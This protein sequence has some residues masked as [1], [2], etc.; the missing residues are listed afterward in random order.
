MAF[1]ILCLCPVFATQAGDTDVTLVSGTSTI[2]SP[3]KDKFRSF[4][5]PSIEG[6]LRMGNL[7]DNVSS[8]LES[9][10]D[11][12][13]HAQL[14]KQGYSLYISLLTLGQNQNILTKENMLP[15]Y[16]SVKGAPRV[17]AF[18]SGWDELLLGTS[19]MVLSDTAAKEVFCVKEKPC[20][21]DL[22]HGQAIANRNVRRHPIWGDNYNEFRFRA[23]YEKF[24]N[25][26]A[27]GLVAWGASL[28]RE[29]F[30]AGKVRLPDYDFDKNVYVMRVKFG[31]RAKTPESH[32]LVYEGDA[33]TLT[34]S[35][36]GNTREV[37]SIVVEWKLPRSEAEILRKRLQKQQS[38]ML[39]FRT[40]GT[41][42]FDTVDRVAMQNPFMLE[43]QSYFEYSGDGI[44]LYTDYDMTDKVVTFDTSKV[45]N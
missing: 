2:P 35:T 32:P 44:T 45:T 23:A 43:R 15:L 33:Y 5:I 10:A 7:G 17:N 3:D 26:Y 12:V 9:K 41:V 34:F 40:K 37:N 29:V 8:K 31:Y 27:E 21:Y 11:R 22:P 19:R 24:V 16:E 1:F 4:L 14:M 6:Y 20:V 18:K 25:E 39:Y 42:N 28:S 36:N 13:K 38:N 30:I